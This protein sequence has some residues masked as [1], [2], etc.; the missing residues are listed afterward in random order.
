M[1]IKWQDTTVTLLS[2]YLIK[3]SSLY[4]VRRTNPFPPTT[5]DILPS[6]KVNFQL[7]CNHPLQSNLN[8][9]AQVFFLN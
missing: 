7:F 1:V 9:A 3:Y 5:K 2:P 8:L 6:K 4:G